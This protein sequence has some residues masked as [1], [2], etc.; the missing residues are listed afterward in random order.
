MKYED[1]QYW[2]RLLNIIFSRKKVFVL[3]Q[4][5]HPN[6]GDQAQLMCTDK[7]LED[8]YPDYK[9]IHLG[10]F[11]PTVNFHAPVDLKGAFKGKLLQLILKWR[12]G[13][14]DFSIG[15]SG[16][17]F[18]DHHEGWKMF[19][20]MMR[21]FPRNKVIILPQTINFFSPKIIEHTSIV[22]N[23]CN[24]VTL[25]CRDEVSY[26]KAQE[27]YPT[28]K[29]LLYP[30]IVTSL[31][32]TRHYNNHRD[33]I[34]F[35]LRDDLEKHYSDAELEKLMSR[36]GDIR[37]GRIDTT[38]YGISTETMDRD[39]NKLIDEMINQISTYEVVITDRYHGTIFS[40][41]ASTPVIVINSADHKLSSGVK[42]FPIEVYGN[43]VQFAE[44]LDD[45]FKKANE[46]LMNEREYSNPDYF[47]RNY[48]DL[49]KE[50]I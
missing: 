14:D 33:G 35:C 32:G 23:Q 50:K 27:Y 45:A 1:K 22:F 10:Y 41:I 21:L 6:L 11:M 12:M 7:W 13:D 40:A 34:L 46:I 43:A 31:I 49:L 18:T 47:K 2:K 16:Y 39:R 25:L 48:W 29:L 9:I 15:H 26:K 20:D 38:L 28:T 19:T 36:F 24:N 3:H 4:P 8:N 37:K 17:F 30:D 44:S 5:T 42:W